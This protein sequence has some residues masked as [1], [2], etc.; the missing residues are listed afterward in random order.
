MTRL[1][2]LTDPDHLPALDRGIAITRPGA[3][4][5]DDQ[6]R[7]QVIKISRRGAHDNSDG[8]SLIKGGL[9]MSAD[10]PQRQAKKSKKE[11]FHTHLHEVI[12]A[13]TVI[14]AGP[15]KSNVASE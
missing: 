6:P 1:R 8:L 7:P 12:L 3:G 10:A 15:I 14:A 2:D 13:L 5:G 4:M 11:P 9:G